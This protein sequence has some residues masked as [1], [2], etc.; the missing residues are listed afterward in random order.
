L[1]SFNGL[2]PNGSWTL[3]IADVASGGGFGT[4]RSWGLEITAIPE[5]TPAALLVCYALVHLIR[6]MS[7]N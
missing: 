6:Q 5:P 4:L 7:R 2:D 3:Y 1:D